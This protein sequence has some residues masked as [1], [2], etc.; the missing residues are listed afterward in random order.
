ML[1]SEWNLALLAE[2]A[3]K[4]PDGNAVSNAEQDAFHCL[5]PCWFY[6]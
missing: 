4:A 3:L 2:R 5:S 6:P 1:A